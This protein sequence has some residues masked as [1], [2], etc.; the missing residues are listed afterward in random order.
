M[1]ITNQS[2]IKLR[3]FE[4]STH[5]ELI[6]SNKIYSHCLFFFSGFNENSSKYVYLLKNF[7]EDNNFNTIKV[8]LPN[9]PSYDTRLDKYKGKIDNDFTKKFPIISSWYSKSIL[10][11]SSQDSFVNEFINKENQDFILNLLKKE[12]EFL[13]N[14]DKIIISGFSQGALYSL[15]NILTIINKKMCFVLLFKGAI[16]NKIELIYSNDCLLNHIHYFYSRFDKLA[17][18]II[19]IENFQ[20]VKKI[21]NHCFITFDDGNLHEVDKQS[22]LYFKKVIKVY[23]YGEKHITKY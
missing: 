10:E 18:V 3:L 4:Y 13:G 15:V 1:E 14:Y 7:L 17:N 12:H 23:V 2:N 19:G 11:I 6:P 9:L 22:L 21:F 20:K 5:S 8:I 16:I